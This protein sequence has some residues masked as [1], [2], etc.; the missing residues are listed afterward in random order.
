MLPAPGF[1]H[2]NSGV[3][4]LP[5]AGGQSEHQGTGRN[6]GSF[7]EER[8][9][10]PSW[11]GQ[12][13]QGWRLQGSTLEGLL[14]PWPASSP[15]LMKSHRKEHREPGLLVRVHE[16]QQNEPG[17]E[18]NLWCSC[19]GCVGLLNPRACLLSPC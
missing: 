9:S 19:G 7:R 8:P 4:V 17:Y 10:H 12:A 2:P 14:C 15:D 6:R 5:R 16:Y 11:R 13:L 18:I 1:A 3:L